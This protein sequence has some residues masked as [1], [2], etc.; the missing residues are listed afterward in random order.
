M[1]KNGAGLSVKASAD[2]FVVGSS[3]LDIIA[4]TSDI[5]RIDI[6]GKHVEHLVCISF[7]SKS[8]LESLELAL[9]EALPIL[10]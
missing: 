6:A 5:E 7:A 1:S 3:T 9:E 8:E 10:P 2:F 4:K